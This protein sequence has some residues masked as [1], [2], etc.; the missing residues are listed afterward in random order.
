[1]GC[2]TGNVEDEPKVGVKGVK[3][4]F[5]LISAAETCTVTMCVILL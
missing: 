1:M 2:C 3:I 5:S 4:V